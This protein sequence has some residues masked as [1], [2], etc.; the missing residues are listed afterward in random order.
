MSENKLNAQ[1]E[2]AVE[3]STIIVGRK[4]D[5]KWQLAVLLHGVFEK[6]VTNISLAKAMDEALDSVYERKFKEGDRIQ[7][8]IDVV[9]E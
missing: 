9:S 2:K 4:V 8:K 6:V 5:G 7:F 1:A 3:N